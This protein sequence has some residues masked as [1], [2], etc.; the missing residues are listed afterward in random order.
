M[1]KWGGRMRC[2]TIQASYRCDKEMNSLHPRVQLNVPPQWT[3]I[4]SKVSD[5]FTNI[6]LPIAIK[7]IMPRE[8]WWQQ[9]SYVLILPP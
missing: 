7:Q 6:L 1:E 3:T 9:Y 2:T 8:R 4:K 5:I